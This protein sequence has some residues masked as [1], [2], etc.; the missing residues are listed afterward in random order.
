M[1]VLAPPVVVR[2]AALRRVLGP[3]AALAAV[4]GLTGCNTSPGAAALVGSSR[5]SVS[6]LQDDVKKAL[7][8]PQVASFAANDK[9][10]FF[11]TELGRLI[12]NKVVTAAAAPYHITVTPDEV[13]Q[14][15]QQFAQSAGGVTALY[16]QAASQA[17]ISQA[18]FPQVIHYYVLEQKLGDALVAN[19]PVSATA[20]QAAYQQNIDQYDQVHAAHILVK[21]K[22][23]ADSILAQ[24]QADPSKFASLAAKYSIDTSNKT[25]GGDLG[26]A[27]RSKF[28]KP[29][30]DAIFAAKPNS[31]IEVHSQFGWHVVHVIAHRVETLKQATPQLR[32]QVL[33]SLRTQK[34]DTALA[35]EAKKLGIHVNP[36][37]GS[38]DDKKNTIVPPNDHGPVGGPTTGPTGNPT[39]PPGG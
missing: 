4:V 22:S 34:L 28:V 26:F 20:L 3:A 14:A 19:V 9:P 17:G 27:G 2:R 24:V 38:W 13:N 6:T 23:L 1:I 18:E 7:K 12:S 29:F 39:A 5:I 25:N 16:Q 15:I 8:D 33:Q 21:S 10:G 37:Y 11:R 31:F 36:R 30:S 35:A 32:P